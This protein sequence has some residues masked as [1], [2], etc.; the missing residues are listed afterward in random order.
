VA[1]PS[2]Q[3]IARS[4]ARN[5]HRAMPLNSVVSSQ[6]SIVHVLVSVANL[7]M[8]AA[9]I[10]GLNKGP[11]NL[12]AL[13]VIGGYFA[14]AVALGIAFVLV[15]VLAVRVPARTATQTFQRQWLGLANGAVVILAWATF[16]VFEE[17]PWK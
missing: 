17:G 14:N 2:S 12:L 8:L 6:M 3:W 4:A 15:I 11:P 16:L 13:G 10:I 5:G 9:F 1:A 7:V